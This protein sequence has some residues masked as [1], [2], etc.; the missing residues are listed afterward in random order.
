MKLLC[1]FYKY[2]IEIKNRLLLLSVTWF[3]AV[4]V[5]YHYKEFLLF[6]IIQPIMNCY[7]KKD[8][9]TYF[10]FTNVTEIFSVF[11]HVV[12][13][14]SNQVLILYFSYHLLVFIS[15]GLFKTEYYTIKFL[16]KISAFL[17]CLL[18]IFFNLFL[19]PLSWDFFISFQEFVS[20]KSIVLHFEAKLNE[21]VSFYLRFYL[22]CI[23][24]C[25]MIVFCIFF[26][27]QIK[28]DLQI[29]NKFRKSFYVLFMVI[30]T[31]LT[32]PDIFSQLSVTILII[33][34]YE[35]IVFGFLL[36]SYLKQMY[37]IS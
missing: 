7:N 32:P 8:F 14:F 9:F 5:S 27:N 10:I 29:L 26:L 3:S 6:I 19:L 31:L 21:Y 12:M 20:M 13:F 24:Y 35:C 28:S 23:F 1:P 4:F 15:P 11:I 34:C 17:F 16:F 33:F 30:S 36:K 22:I 25:L 18:I 2:Y 37:D